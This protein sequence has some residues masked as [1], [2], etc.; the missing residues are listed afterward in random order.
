MYSSTP[1]L[2]L[3]LKARQLRA[4]FVERAIGLLHAMADLAKLEVGLGN[5]GHASRIKEKANSFYE[6]TQRFFPSF[7][8]TDSDEQRLK[9]R[10]QQ[11]RAILDG[12]ISGSTDASH[13][14]QDS[15][16]FGPSEIN[17]IFDQEE[18]TWLHSARQQL[19]RWQHYQD[20]RLRSNLRENFLAA[21]F[22]T[23][24]FKRSHSRIAELVRRIDQMSEDEF[25]ELYTK[26]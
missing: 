7:D 11:I 25:G 15:N 22:K 6:D 5:S 23:T 9:A 26:L 16:E 8:M 18:S 20:R 24:S 12:V 14:T 13:L 2:E 21:L 19:E 4:V 10:L 3:R 1:N 17:A